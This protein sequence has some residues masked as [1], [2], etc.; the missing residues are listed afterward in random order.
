MF[1]S[2]INLK[3]IKFFLKKRRTVCNPNSFWILTVQDRSKTAPASAV[4]PLETL[5]F[6]NVIDTDS[7]LVKN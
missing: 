2:L 7:L 6:S 5:E 1:C 3:K 4:L